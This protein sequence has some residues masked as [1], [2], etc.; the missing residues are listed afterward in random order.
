[1]YSEASRAVLRMITRLFRS[2]VS[3]DPGLEDM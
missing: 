1:M 2:G 3:L